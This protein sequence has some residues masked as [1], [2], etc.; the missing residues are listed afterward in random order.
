MEPL[1][2]TKLHAPRRR[3]GVV[4][5]ARLTERLDR[6]DEAVLTL[7]SAPAGF[8]KTTLVTEWLAV[9]APGRSIA[10]LSL[11]ER[12]NDPVVFWTYLVSA[13]QTA[14]DRVGNGALAVLQEP[15]AAMD[16]VLATL[17]NE[18][19]AASGDVVLVLDDYH[20]IATRE[21]HDRLAFLLERL[22]PNVHLVI[23]TRADPALPLARL[24]ARG[25]L[26]EV[27]AA[28]LRFT[29]DE[30]A[31]YLNEAM[32]LALPPEHVAAL[33]AR[34][35]GWIAALQLAALSMQGRDDLAAFIAGFAGDDRYI[36]DY[37][38][39]E[40]L[41]RQPEVVRDFLLSTAVLSRLSGPLC[42]VVVG[43]DGGAA[44]LEDLDRANLFLVPLDDRRH[45]YRYH[46]LFADVLHARLLAE[47]PERV[48]VLHRRASEWWARDEEPG[49]A[50]R[51][52][53]AGG[54]PERAAELV[55][56]AMPAARQNRQETTLRHWFKQLPEHVLRDRPVLRAGY[57]GAILVHGEVDGVEE[58][59]R[60]A[61]RWLEA[62]GSREPVG[63]SADE[64]VVRVVRSQVAVYRAAQARL[65][66]DLQGTVTHAERVLELAGDDEHLVRG[67]AAGLLGLAH[68]TSGDLDAAHRWWNESR[69]QLHRAGHHSDTL[70]VSIALAD[71]DLARG[72]LR[73]A[74]TTYEAGLTT[75]A[76]HDPRVL[77]GVADMHV[78]LS[79]LFLERNEL[80]AAHEHLALSDHL[81]DGA[82]LP[83]NRHRSRIAMARLRAAEGDPDA[84][85]SLLDEAERL[86]VGDMFPDVRPIPAVRARMWVAQHRV[87]EALGWARERGLSPDDALSYLR[88]FEHA[89][90]ARILLAQH[91]HSGDPTSLVQATGLLERLVEA[92]G[93][94]RRRGS[95]IQLS[96]HLALARQAGGD[97]PAALASLDRALTLAAPEGHVRV[98]LDEGQAMASLLRT[99]E[100]GGGTHAHV[101]RLLDA[102][103]APDRGPLAQQHLIE[104]LSGRELEV[105]RLL[106]TDLDGPG[107]A[108]ELYLSLNT[109]RTHTR[110]VY[111][112]L[113]VNS[114][115]AAVR[116]AGELG[117]L[118]RRPQR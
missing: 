117:L 92:A 50:I 48:P 61:E 97:V 42:D 27:R 29:A 83:Q 11:D 9:A 58:H 115:R 91:E 30:A 17:V 52:A 32:G 99:L 56:L 21:V 106:G 95:V 13:L 108:R 84:A 77:R 68:W 67:S 111:A 76:R 101:R 73:D 104:P 54:D 62:V 55:E 103:P 86:Y 28:D 112:K 14:V 64:A 51:H 7:I 110:N 113:G 18:L 60:D 72:R 59:L 1:L 107:I 26:V 63:A 78:G 80:E 71:I 81:G 40:V 6:G 89:T 96:V 15:H 10:W 24:R 33:D 44:M 38:V 57:A 74:R 94:G 105:L 12:D 116:R 43:R 39:E 16:E 46:H 19:D 47:Q 70:G 98:F 31:A 93:A 90:L 4:A 5:R 69:A 45:W 114:R 66:G 118:P 3:R 2:S 75:A 85:V 35:E 65:T 22:P 34:T 41:Q 88:E 87:G 100:T 8:G 20:V 109:V 82:G 49:E 25:Q 53:L 37:L 79:E 36:V 102:D 23:A